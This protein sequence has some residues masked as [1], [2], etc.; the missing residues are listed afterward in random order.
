MVEKDV[1]YSKQDAYD[2]IMSNFPYRVWL[3]IGC[4]QAKQQIVHT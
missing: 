2:Q 3:I 4:N 1:A